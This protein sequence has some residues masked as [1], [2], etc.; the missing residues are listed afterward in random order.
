MY[1]A[2][3]VC[4][5]KKLFDLSYFVE[6]VLYPFNL[7][8]KA[9]CRDLEMNYGSGELVELGSRR[10]SHTRREQRESLVIKDTVRKSRVALD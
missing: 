10:I 5:V 4:P 9:E 3:L 1:I 2:V 7:D 8:R 6:A